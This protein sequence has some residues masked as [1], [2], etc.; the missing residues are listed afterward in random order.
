LIEGHERFAVHGR[1][2]VQRVGEVQSLQYAGQGGGGPYWIFQGHGRQTGEAGYR[3]GA[4]HAGKLIDA[5]Q[6]PFGL[7]QHGRGDEHRLAVDQAACR[8]RLGWMIACE[9]ADDQIGI[10]R[11]HDGD[12]LRRR[13]RRPR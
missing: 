2:K 3:G 11:Q 4:G 8:R 13:C 10:N 5:S 6:N 1:S 12:V 7:E 9:V